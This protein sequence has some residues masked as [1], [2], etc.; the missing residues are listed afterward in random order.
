MAKEIDMFN[1]WFDEHAKMSMFTNSTIGD[2]KFAFL[3][4]WEAAE[5][6]V[7]R[8]AIQ[9]APIKEFVDTLKKYVD[10]DDD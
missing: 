5:Q 3:A 4:G 9:P 6:S 2:L 7:E 1:K 10:S 8:T